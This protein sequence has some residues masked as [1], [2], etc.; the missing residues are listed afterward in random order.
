MS[1][2]LQKKKHHHI[3]LSFDMKSEAGKGGGGV[4]T[5]KGFFRLS[6]CMRFGHKGI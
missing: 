2:A 5:D 6:E 3:D 1:F 4:N